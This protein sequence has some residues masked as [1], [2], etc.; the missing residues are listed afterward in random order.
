MP[1]ACLTEP[2]EP[3]RDFAAAAPDEVLALL[4]ALLQALIEVQNHE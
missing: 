1:W 2:D 3:C 4:A